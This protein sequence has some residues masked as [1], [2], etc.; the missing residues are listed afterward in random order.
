[1]QGTRKFGRVLNPNTM[2]WEFQDGS[3]VSVPDELMPRPGDLLLVWLCTKDR[4]E[5]A[6]KASKDGGK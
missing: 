3:G 6:E 1:M 4:L 5:R 2:M